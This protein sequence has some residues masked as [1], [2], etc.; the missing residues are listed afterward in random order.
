[1]ETN[2]GRQV[3]GSNLIALRL[4]GAFLAMGLA[5][6]VHAAK[7]PSESMK[8]KVAKKSAASDW[9]I[10]GGFVI[11]G[12]TGSVQTRVGMIKGRFPVYAGVDLDLL[13]MGGWGYSY[14]GLTPMA[15]AMMLIPLR[16]SIVT[17]TV[18]LAAGPSFSFGGYSFLG[19]GGGTAIG[20]AVL[21]K[22]GCLIEV[23]KGIEVDVQLRLGA[24]GGMMMFI[25]QAGVRFAI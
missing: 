8:T 15:S 18:G 16:A 19:R 11:P 17:P 1:M 12:L 4:M 7:A 10:S 20:L 9:R 14:V 3:N 21:V 24:V 23:D 22:A 25:P 6:N 5:G 2:G 13:F